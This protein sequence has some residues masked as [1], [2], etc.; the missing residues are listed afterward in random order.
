MNEQKWYAHKTVTGEQWYITTS[1]EL[2][3]GRVVAHNMIMADAEEVCRAHN[4]V[5]DYGK[6]LADIVKGASPLRHPLDIGDAV[7]EVNARQGTCTCTFTYVRPCPLHINDTYEQR[8]DRW[9]K[10]HNDDEHDAPV[11]TTLCDTC[12]DKRWIEPPPG[13]LKAGIV[14]EDT[15]LAP[16]PDCNPDGHA[17]L[18]NE[19]D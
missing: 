9:R 15:G 8:R 6:S 13:A 17:D 18:P 3:R 7:D 19:D 5:I 2:G 10:F 1:G 11:N 12:D 4:F 16:C 14:N